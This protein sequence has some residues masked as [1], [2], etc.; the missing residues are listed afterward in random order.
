MP[1]TTLVVEDGSFAFTGGHVVPGAN[2]Y[3]DVAYLT[4]I[5]LNFYGLY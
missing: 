3:I 1:L 5:N 4:T 2:T